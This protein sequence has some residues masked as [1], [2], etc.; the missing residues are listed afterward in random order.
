[1]WLGLGGAA[2]A[3]ALKRFRSR[4]DP[5]AEQPEVSNK[6][7]RSVSQKQTAKHDADLCTYGRGGASRGPSSIHNQAGHPSHRWKVSLRP[8]P[9]TFNEEPRSTPQDRIRRQPRTPLS[10]FRSRLGRRA[11]FPVMAEVAVEILTHCLHGSITRARLRQ[12]LPRL[13]QWRHREPPPLCSA[14]ALTARLTA[15]HTPHQ[16]PSLAFSQH[17]M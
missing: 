10:P 5:E 14:A 1:M 16:T 7:C 6:A 3:A 4:N 2:A 8:G 12:D 9:A 17:S 11:A 15:M 13:H